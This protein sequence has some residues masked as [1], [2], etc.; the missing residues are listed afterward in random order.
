M[1][2]TPG[3]VAE[4]TVNG[5][6]M[7]DQAAS[8]YIPSEEIG[9]LQPMWDPSAPL[10][11]TQCYTLVYFL[12]LLSIKT[13]VTEQKASVHDF[14]FSF[15][16]APDGKDRRGDSDFRKWPCSE[17]GFCERHRKACSFVQ[18]A[19]NLRMRHTDIAHWLASTGHRVQP[20]RPSTKNCP[21]F[22]W[23]HSH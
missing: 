3:R 5:E 14:I 11:F 23:L 13:P 10:V 2:F 19:S 22:S 6:I 20:R 18:Q 15:S 21:Q 4:A 1:F 17:G 12:L 9:K 7:L 8:S 16:R